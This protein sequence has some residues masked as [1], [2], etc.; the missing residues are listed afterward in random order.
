[1]KKYTFSLIAL[2]LGLHLFAQDS[3]EMKWGKVSDEELAMTEYDL[4]P[5]A[6]AVVLFDH[7][8]LKFDY[9]DGSARF[10]LDR[11]RRVKILK[12]S[13]FDQGDIQIRYY[14]YS[15]IEKIEQLKIQIFSPDG[16]KTTVDKSAIFEE[17]ENNYWSVI[18]ISIPN[19]QEGSVFEYR[20]SLVADYIF[21]LNPWQFQE[22][23]PI[24]WSEFYMEIPDWFDYVFLKQRTNLC[25][26]EGDVLRRSMT[27]PKSVTD[28]N[29]HQLDRGYQTVNV[30]LRSQRMA[31]K[32]VPG[33]KEEPFIT[34]MEDYYAR[35]QFQLKSVEY[36]NA[37]TKFVMTNW[38]QVCSELNESESFGNQLN[39]ALN[40]NNAWQD[41]Q[42]VLD[43]I[44]DPTQKANAIYDALSSRMHWDGLRGIYV[45]KSLDDLY[46]K[47][48]GS[49]GEINLLLI[50]MLRKAGLNTFPL[51]VSTRAHGQMFELYPFLSQFN[52]VIAATLIGEEAILMD[53]G[54]PN[55]PSGLLPVQSL[56]GRALLM[57]PENPI[58]VSVPATT[59]KD[60]YYGLLSVNEEGTIEGTIKT[61]HEGYAALNYRDA[62]LEESAES[63]WQE[64]MEEN[65][66]GCIVS[67]VSVENREDVYSKLKQEFTVSLPKA[68][69]AAG[70][71]I[72][73]N[74]VVLSD[75][76]E[77]PF[78][79]EDRTYP[80]NIPYPIEDKYIFNLTIPEGFEIEELPEPTRILMDGNAGLFQYNVS[81]S[82]GKVQ[83][84]VEIKLFV[85]TYPP[86]Q[87]SVI[88]NFFDIVVEKLNEP[89]V[90]KRQ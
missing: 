7:G 11:H 88:K 76:K 34:T 90:L 18:K 89:V 2:C 5:D 23:I 12:R 1:M 32:D 63:I 14:S 67:G 33:L 72:Y 86:E 48:I 6:G 75:F 36:P 28:G 44:T 37:P 77:N 65:Y 74:P 21:T 71:F 39:N 55:R 52:H 60:V 59:S 62:F 13:G 79:I 80:V 50:A 25:I 87:Y 58:W 61:S 83:I 53:L 82:A 68:G 22:D 24:R 4:D 70:D 8:E 40:Y 17:E 66:P 78:T 47:Q 51:L 57:N 19:I 81:E 85:L 43:G 42:P 73:V 3:P 15:N 56:A 30:N 64:T 46:R 38:E 26:E 27:I 84:V 20:Y 45:D 54:N 16:T 69:Q 41:L 31:M 10:R 9:S 49:S 29:G 35:V